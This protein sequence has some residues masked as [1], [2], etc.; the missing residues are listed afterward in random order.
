MV[1]LIRRI[2]LAMALATAA[3]CLSGSSGF[4]ETRMSVYGDPSQW[5]CGY[6]LDG[7]CQ[8][9]WGARYSHHWWCSDQGTPGDSPWSTMRRGEAVGVAM[10]WPTPLGIWV[11]IHAPTPDGGTSVVLARVVDRGPYAPWDIDAGQDLVEQLGWTAETWG[12]Q[13]VT[14]RIRWDLDR[15]CPR[16]GYGD[17][18][19]EPPLMALSPEG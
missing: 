4:V 6:W 18:S 1:E 2:G 10:R 9:Y 15:Y 3:L 14:Y 12:L 5:D 8:G 7:S 17:S 16:Y 13:W 19:H 11:E